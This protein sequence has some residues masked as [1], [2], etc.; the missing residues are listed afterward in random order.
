M[1][2]VNLKDS[3]QDAPQ[4]MIIRVVPFMEMILPLI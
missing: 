2:T 4:G 3:V 1:T